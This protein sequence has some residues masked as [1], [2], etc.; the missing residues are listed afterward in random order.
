MFTL[1][2][3]TL[4]MGILQL[5]WVLLHLSLILSNLIGHFDLGRSSNHPQFTGQEGNGDR[6]A[7]DFLLDGQSRVCT[8]H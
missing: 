7:L 8:T 2:A 3:L 6:I 1:Q 5:E 4:K